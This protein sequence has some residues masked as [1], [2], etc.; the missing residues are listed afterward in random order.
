[1]SS[2][3]F[4]RRLELHMSRTERLASVSR[5]LL[6]RLH[7]LLRV[8]LCLPERHVTPWPLEP[9]HGTSLG[10]RVSTDDPVKMS[11]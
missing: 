11:H 3:V 1:M 9:V 8:Q 7:P 5:R 2:G 10:N 6:A 4:T